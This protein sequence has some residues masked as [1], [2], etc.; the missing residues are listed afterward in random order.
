MKNTL[1]A[2]VL[3]ALICL[4]LTVSASK[5]AEKPNILLI[6]ADDAIW[7]GIQK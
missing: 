6:V 5:A 3:C 1:L 4:M 2:K 7:L